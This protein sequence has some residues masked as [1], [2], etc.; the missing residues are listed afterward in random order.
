M[1]AHGAVDADEVFR[2]TRRFPSVPPRAP[3]D[4]YAVS[5]DWYFQNGMQGDEVY[6]RRF[7]TIPAPAT[8]G[9]FIETVQRIAE[10][11]NGQIYGWRGQSDGSWAIHSGAMR[12]VMQPW[13]QAFP[14]DRQHVRELVAAM[15]EDMGIVDNKRDVARGD[16]D[17]QL[18]WDMGMYQRYLINEARTLGFD[19]H[20]G[21]QLCDL[22]LLALLQH[23]GA[24]TH[25]LD[26]SRDVMTALWFAASERPE[27]IGVVA[28]FDDTGIGHL[29][30]AHAKMGF[31]QLMDVL[32]GY[33]DTHTTKHPAVGWI[34]R[35]LTARIL[36]QRGVFVL[37]GHAD[38]PW[39][40]VGVPG[41]YAWQSDVEA[42]L[43]D[44]LI[45][46]RAFFVA[47]RPELKREVL[48]AGEAGLFGVDPTSL[49]PDLVGFAHANRSTEKVPI[50]L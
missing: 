12:R 19:R 38:Q 4:D 46:P 49:F 37:S 34:P 50:A 8:L 44:P 11:A 36:A 32:Q 35:I 20:E 1:S 21:E 16:D 23:N 47:V 3:I 13:I 10:A 40:S 25:L 17:P 30:P 48:K 45:E 43:V 15:R 6:L 42:G 28:G 9:E 7:G 27:T 24:A 26:L 29:S 5:S 39:G 18:W 33:S 22:E 14:A 41:T 2:R 31:G